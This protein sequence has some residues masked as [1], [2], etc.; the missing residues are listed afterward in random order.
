M[1]SDTTT[2]SPPE[3]NQIDLKPQWTHVPDP[4]RSLIGTLMHDSDALG[5]VAVI[6][7]SAGA[8]ESQQYRLIYDAIGRLATQD[9]KVDALAIAGELG[10]D[11]VRVGGLAE[12]IGIETEVP[13]PANSIYYAQ[14]VREAAAERREREVMETEKRAH[15]AVIRAIDSRDA[16]AIDDAKRDLREIIDNRGAAVARASRAV[17]RCMADIEP[18]PIEWLWEGRIPAG[19]P[20]IVDGPPGAGKS[21]MLLDLAARVSSGRPMPLSDLVRRPRGVLIVAPEDSAAHTIRPRLDLAGAVPERVHLFEHVE[22]RPG[23][24]RLVRLPDDIGLIE[25]QVR[26]QD[27]G[28]VII[29]SLMSTLG[30]T[31]THADAPVRSALLPLTSMAERTGAAVMAIRHWRKAGGVDAI[32]RGTGSAAFSALTRSLL[33][34]A[35][36]PDDRDL[37]VLAVAKVSIAP[38]QKSLGFRLVPDGE[39]C[40]VEWS[41]EPVE[42]TADDLVADRTPDRPRRAPARDRGM[43]LLR[44]LLVAGPIPKRAIEDAANREGISWATVKRAKRELGITS[45]ERDA[46]TPNQHWAWSLSAAGGKGQ[47]STEDHD[48]EHS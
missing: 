29:D 34:C 38:D 7:G 39:H 31:E 41:E 15:A 4:E 32:T 28:L 12:L 21:T 13:S 25:E 46:R 33:T 10:A 14:L 22:I 45:I 18:K 26:E 42:Y 30:N 47:P 9:A 27:V 44:R 2:G 48:T 36:S 24:D 6:I 19:M 20:T 8:I 11:L 35:R 17:T 3:Q 43:D 40:R 16:C 37:R 23:I 1:S 5:A